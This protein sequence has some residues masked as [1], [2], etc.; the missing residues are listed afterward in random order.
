MTT[1]HYIHGPLWKSGKS[2]FAG[3]RPVPIRHTNEA[4]VCRIED[5]RS[6]KKLAL[7]VTSERDLG[8]FLSG[9]RGSNSRHSA[10]EADTLPTELRSQKKEL[11]MNF[12]CTNLTKF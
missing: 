3:R 5:P 6:D 8:I 10:W 11:T 4:S 12:Y 7:Q 1:A 2:R 9:R